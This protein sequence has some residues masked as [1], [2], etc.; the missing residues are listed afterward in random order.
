[1][2]SIQKYVS[3][4]VR[5]GSQD[6]AEVIGKLFAPVNILYRVLIIKCVT[7][8]WFHRSRYEKG[9]SFEKERRGKRMKYPRR[10]ILKSLVNYVSRDE[11]VRFKVNRCRPIFTAR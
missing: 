1:M 5:S 9:S 4:D 10:E 11:L 8:S 7:R 6:D 2:K 3:S